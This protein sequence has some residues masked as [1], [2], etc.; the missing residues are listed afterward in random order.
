MINRL[1]LIALLIG[2]AGQAPAQ[3]VTDAP[4]LAVI[5]LILENG[6]SIS[7][8]DAAQIFPAAGFERKQVRN[9]TKS[10]M[11]LGILQFQNE[12]LTFV[13]ERCNGGEQA[14]D[15]PVLPPLV[16]LQETYV[17]I[18]SLS[19]CAI[20][21]KDMARFFP[22]TGNM[23]IGLAYALEEGLTDRGVLHGSS[24]GNGLEIGIDY[25]VP[26]ASYADASGF[27][28]TEFEAEAIEALTFNHCRVKASQIPDVFP[29]GET[30]Q[31]EIRRALGSLM[32][33]GFA[34]MTVGNDI[35]SISPQICVP[36][37]VR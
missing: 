19:N 24:D 32:N 29:D 23:P 21:T 7:E 35:I 6:C 10:L 1:T 3:A 15:G 9:I 11:E 30:N 17:Y 31:P 20:Q 37:S 12:R 33:A 16:E 36:W 27:Q 8:S 28:P 5:D 22:E 18:M 13:D 14:Y 26:M 4:S 25:C 34:Q 2:I